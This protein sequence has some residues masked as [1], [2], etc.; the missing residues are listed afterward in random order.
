MVCVHLIS[1]F[2]TLHSPFPLGVYSE[3]VRCCTYIQC[4]LWLMPHFAITLS[5]ALLSTHSDQPFYPHTQTSPSIHTLRPALLST[6]SDQPFYPYTQTSPSI[7]TLRPALLS[8]HSDQPF[9]PHT[10]TS[11]SIHTLRPALL[12]THSDQ[13]FYPHTQT[14]PSIHTEVAAVDCVNVY[15]SFNVS[16]VTII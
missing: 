14:S 12:S 5:P 8:T 13:P 9:Y 2:E 7:H 4:P 6:H 10:Q 11:P 3:F 16:A 1:S 15:L